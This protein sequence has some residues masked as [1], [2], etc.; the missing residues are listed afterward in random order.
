MPYSVKKNIYG[1]S[2]RIAVGGRPEN[3]LSGG[4]KSPLAQ[5]KFNPI[6]IQYN[7][8]I[9]LPFPSRGTRRKDS[10]IEPVAYHS[11]PSQAVLG[12]GNQWVKIKCDQAYSQGLMGLIL[13]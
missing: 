11:L 3:E 9:L 8:I 5:T 2:N 7:P 13:K 4:Q 10:D 12:L 6:S 1:G